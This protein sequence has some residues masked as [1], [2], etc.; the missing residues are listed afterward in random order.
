MSD[1]VVLADKDLKKKVVIGIV[2]FGI[3]GMGMIQGMIFYLEELKSLATTDL[4]SAI[5]RLKNV[6]MAVAVIN[7]FISIG[8]GWHLVRIAVRTWKTER[9]PP[10]G[11]RVV[12][13]TKVKTGSKAKGVAVVGLVL[14]VVVILSTN[15]S[16]WYL[17]I[18]VDMLLRK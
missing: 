9:Y 2:L 12:K 13:D 4:E 5:D 11:M 8:V 3:L 16:L 1:K 6:L 10:E 7:A 18:L 14:A 17:W 15:L